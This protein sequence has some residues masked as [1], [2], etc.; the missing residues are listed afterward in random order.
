VITQFLRYYGGVSTDTGSSKKQ[1]IAIASPFTSIIIY[2]NYRF[3][4]SGSCIEHLGEWMEITALLWLMNQ[5]TYSPFMGTLMVTLRYLPMII[6]AFLGGII[7]DRI[8][9]RNLLIYSLI[10]SG[11]AALLMSVVVYT[12]W[13]QPWHLLLYSVSAG[14]FTSFNH[15]A[16][17]T[18]LPNLVQREHFLNAITLDNASVMVSRLLGAPLAG[19]IVGAWGITPVI[20]LRALG[21]LAAIFLLSRIQAQVAPTAARKESPLHNLAEGIQYVGK[22]RAVL[23]QILLYLLPVFIQNSYTGLLPYFATNVLNIGPDLY[24]IMNAAP[25]FGAI[26]AIL[27]VASFVNIRQKLPFLAIAG[28]FQGLSLVLFIFS[29]DYMLSLLFLVMVGISGTTFMTLNN[30]MIQ[31]MTPDEVKGRVMS[32]REVA[33]GMGPAGSLVSGYI[34]SLISVSAAIG[35][36]GGIS[37]AILLVVLFVVGANRIKLNTS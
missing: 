33:F 2:K 17:N 11:I 12:G 30:T 29:P 14:I 10:A 4:W 26:I 9:R 3:F 28:V 21:I 27:V 24:G 32:L 31:E 23:T 5:L 13:V 15:P 19:L 20:L 36:S 7:A 8:N 22:N 34:A 18:L 1:H 35:I 25:G 16:R 6:F 37:I